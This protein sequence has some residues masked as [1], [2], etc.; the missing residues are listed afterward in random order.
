MIEYI[1]EKDAWVDYRMVLEQLFGNK[2]PNRFYSPFLKDVYYSI[3]E[4]ISIQALFDRLEDEIC[5]R[6]F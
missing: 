1:A 6:K 4:K 3:A 5:P 2:S